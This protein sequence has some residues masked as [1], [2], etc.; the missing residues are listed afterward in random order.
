MDIINLPEA[1]IDAPSYN[2][3]DLFTKEGKM[4]PEIRETINRVMA[5]LSQKFPQ[6]KILDYF[7]TGS[8]VTQQ[9]NKDSDIDTSIVL[10]KDTS[11]ELQK[12][13][14]EY[15]REVEKTVAPFNGAR[16]YQFTPQTAQ[17]NEITNVD[18]AYDIK[19]DTWIKRPDVTKVNTDYQNIIADPNSKEHQLY[20]TAERSIQPTLQRLHAGVNNNIDTEKLKYFIEKALHSYE[21]IKKWRGRM[22]SQDSG[23]RISQNWGPG[24]IIYKFLN[25]EGYIK[26]F[27]F[28]KS[29][30]KTNYRIDDSI[31]TS[32]SNL[33]RS[34]VDDEIGF[35]REEKST[36]TGPFRKYIDIIDE[37]S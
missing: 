7:V 2:L 31:K 18:A 29:I 37:N 25:A 13:F 12:E 5:N 14:K 28:L 9:Y 22:Y 26:V 30:K 6:V 35:V 1:V 27:E 21:I 17:R 11:P 19:Q 36:T 20:S 16:P 23:N 33:L 10:A 34:V 24:N 32:L 4:Q 15:C 3:S 8:G